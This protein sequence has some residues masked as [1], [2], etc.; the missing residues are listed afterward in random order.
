[1]RYWLGSLLVGRRE[2]LRFEDLD[3]L[4]LFCAKDL[5]GPCQAILPKPGFIMLL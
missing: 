1:M 2:L 5:F 3:S 4:A